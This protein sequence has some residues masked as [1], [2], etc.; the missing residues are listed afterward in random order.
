[1]TT[2]QQGEKDQNRIVSQAT[3]KGKQ[4]AEWSKVGV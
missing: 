1:M 4:L 3:G 2:P